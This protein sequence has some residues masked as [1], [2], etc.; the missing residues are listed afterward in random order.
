MES[1]NL[2]IHLGWRWRGGGVYYEWEGRWK[3]EGIRTS[4]FLFRVRI[5]K[6]IVPPIY[7]T[8]YLLKG[9]CSTRH[10]WKYSLFAFRVRG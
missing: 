4:G 5:S 9:D 3:P 8:F 7:P 10:T 2:L 1:T 6:Y